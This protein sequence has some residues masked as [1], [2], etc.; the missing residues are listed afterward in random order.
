MFLSMWAKQAG[1]LIW[2]IGKLLVD[3]QNFS[4]SMLSTVQPYYFCC[5]LALGSKFLVALHPNQPYCSRN[6][7]SSFAGCCIHVYTTYAA[8]STLY[9]LMWR[10]LALFQL[11]LFTD[12]IFFFQNSNVF[13]NTLDFSSVLFGQKLNTR[14]QNYCVEVHQCWIEF[15]TS[16]DKLYNS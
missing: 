9:Y 2:V 15:R 5:L 4:D 13:N 8:S 16:E 11:C 3:S 12:M 1:S 14:V 10:I 6:C 7:L